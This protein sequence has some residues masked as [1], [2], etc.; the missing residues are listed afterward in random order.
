MEEIKQTQKKYCSQAMFFAIAMFIVFLLLG[1]KAIGKGFLLGT[2]FSVINFV[3]MGQLMPLYLGKKTHSKASA[4]ALVSI[5]L[6][7]AIL[8]VPLVISLKISSIHFIGVVIGLFTVQLAILF[9]QIIINRLH[10]MRKA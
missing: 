4:F 7:F 9:D 3:V 10:I 2:L 6:R 8:A 5:L 1:E